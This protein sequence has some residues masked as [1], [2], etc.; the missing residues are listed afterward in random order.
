VDRIAQKAGRAAEPVLDALEKRSLV[1]VDAVVSF[2]HRLSQHG[3]HIHSTC[4][5]VT[6]LCLPNK[7]TNKRTPW[8][9]VRKR[10]IPT[11]DRHLSIKFSAN[12]GG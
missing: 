4:T 11:Y 9:L 5:K 7:Q 1:P 2:L 3:S 8:P 6:T 10:T 12:F